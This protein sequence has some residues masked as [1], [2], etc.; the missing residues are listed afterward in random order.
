MPMPEIRPVRF[1]VSEDAKL[2]RAHANLS[3]HHYTKESESRLR[4]FAVSPEAGRRLKEVCIEM[5]KEKKQ[6]LVRFKIAS[7][8]RRMEPWKM[9]RP[10]YREKRRKRF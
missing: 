9:W 3:F 1:N 2:C 7:G 10:G 6:P 4:G 8:I 5:Q